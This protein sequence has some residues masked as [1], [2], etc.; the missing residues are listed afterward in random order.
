MS[1]LVE[2]NY[3]NLARCSGKRVA[4]DVETTGLHWW[5]HHLI[6]VG[7]YCPDAD[8]EAYF[9]CKPNSQEEMMLKNAIKKHIEPGTWAFL[10]NAKF[11]FH[12]L[13]LNPYKSGWKYIDTAVLG[14]LYDSKMMKKMIEMERVFLGTGTKREHLEEEIPRKI[15]KKVWEWNIIDVANYCCNDCRVTYELAQYLV[16]VIEDLGL[17]DLLRKEMQYLNVIWKTERLGVKTDKKYL[18]EAQELLDAQTEALEQELRDEI[19]VI[20]DQPLAEDFNW[21]SPQQLSKALYEQYGWKKPVNPFVGADGVDRSKFAGRLYNKTMTNTF[22]LSEKAKH[23]LAELVS[24]LRESYKLSH[25][26]IDQ[27]KKLMGDGDVIHS[28]FN[29]TGTKTGRL[30]SSKPNLQNLPS[31]ARVRFTQAVY[32]GSIERTGEYNL[33]N[34]F[35][36]RPGKTFVATDWRQMELRLFGILSEDPNMLQSLT[37]GRDVHA[38]VAERVWG[39]RDKVHREWAKTISFG[40]IYGTTAGSLEHRLDVTREQARKM[41]RDYWTAY[42]NIMPWINGVI[43]QCEQKMYLRMWNN[44]IWREEDPK[45]M[46]VGANAIIQGGCAGVLQVAAIRFDEWIERMGYQNKINI[47]SFV[48]DEIITEVDDE[49]VQETALAMREIMEVPDL[50][51]IPW[52]TDT[53]IGHSFGTLEDYDLELGKVVD[54]ELAQSVKFG[55][56][57]QESLLHVSIEGA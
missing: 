37:E 6:G 43:K 26:Y 3:G 33:R 13:D 29:L 54:K 28:S 56:E 40:L 7:V 10:H 46:Y 27:W 42:P 35:I 5:Q 48:H 20:S 8:Y 51:D 49:M 53:A 57:E 24:N 45:K 38:D 23:P 25:S 34:A 47:V 50:F 52:F 11:D 30:S 2:N 19:E 44:R 39:I 41:T 32:S 16:P 55:G 21:R 4:I 14:H 31:F 22:L 1:N 17:W 9:P 18:N 36:T 15:K 12:F